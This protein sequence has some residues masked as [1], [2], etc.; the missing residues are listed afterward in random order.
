MKNDVYGKVYVIFL[1]SVNNF[2]LKLFF[3]CIILERDEI[4]YGV[5]DK[6]L[7]L[8]VKFIIL[9][10]FLRREISTIGTGLFQRI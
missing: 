6:I 3:F 1:V 10:K 5:F 4:Y 9:T 7:F 2:F 8:I